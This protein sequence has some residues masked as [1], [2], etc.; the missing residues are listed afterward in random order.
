[1]YVKLSKK[2]ERI[3]QMLEA[4][5]VSQAEA[6]ELVGVTRQ[7]VHQWVISAGLRPALA[8]KRHLRDLLRHADL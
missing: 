8:R 4:G 1:M 2:R 5:Y 3:L 7:R 6:A